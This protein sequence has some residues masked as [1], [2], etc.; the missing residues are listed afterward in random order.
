M[1]ETIPNTSHPCCQ[2]AGLRS[3]INLHSSAAAGLYSTPRFGLISGY[4]KTPST[5]AMTVNDTEVKP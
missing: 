4:I 3:I 1:S 5:A 2:T